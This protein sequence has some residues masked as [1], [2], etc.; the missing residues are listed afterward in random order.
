MGHSP[1]KLY[2]EKLIREFVCVSI[3]V[4]NIWPGH[5][6]ISKVK[7]FSADPVALESPRT[8]QLLLISYKKGASAV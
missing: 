1:F 3:D 5:S 6:W 7:A 2:F 4:L 8:A